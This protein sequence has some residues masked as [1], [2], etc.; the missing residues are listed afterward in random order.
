MGPSLH[1]LILVAA[2]GAG[3]GSRSPVEPAPP[4]PGGE[5]GAE[6]ARFLDW[7]VED[8]LFDPKRAVGYVRIG[9]R[10]DRGETRIDRGFRVYRGE[11]DRLAAGTEGWLVRGTNGNP[12]RI[13]VLDGESIP[14]P[15][16]GVHE[17]D[18]MTGRPIIPES[19]GGNRV[20]RL[21]RF[22][23]NDALDNPHLVR[24]AWLRRLGYDGLAATELAEARDAHDD[25][26]RALR[27]AL[28]RRTND[29]AVRAFADRNDTAA[30]AHAA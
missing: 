20:L 4:R 27:E 26:V 28:A 25:P 11:W 13:Y 23:E 14:V 3:P 5:L 16:S 9:G 2:I 21:V 8:F 18:F 24:A 30:V 1:A 22:G 7:L 19:A 12:D 6:D 29:L 15:P 10:E 17:A